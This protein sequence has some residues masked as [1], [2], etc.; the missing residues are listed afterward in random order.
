[1]T[2]ARPLRPAMPEV[3]APELAGAAD[4]RVFTCDLDAGGATGLAA[5]RALLSPDERRRAD[6]FRFERDR[7]RYTRGRAF[8]RRRL[9]TATQRPAATL[10]LIEG[11]WGKPAL[12]DGA[13]GFNLSHSGAIAVLA[14]RPDGG[15]VG[16]DVER[17]DRAVDVMRL[18]QSC[19]GCDERAVLA[20]LAPEAQRRRF[21]AFWTAKE[22]VMKLTG[23]GMSL[24]PKEIFLGLSD[25]H[26]VRAEALGW[27]ERMTFARM[28]FGDDGVECRL[29]IFGALSPKIHLERP[30]TCRGVR[31]AH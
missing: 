14:I 30:Q 17:I 31:K 26:P 12:Q 29:A 7:A 9:A 8:L 13:V 4:V 15:P 22:A 6:R 5:D 16:I 28:P 27:Q 1:M 11:E 21:F 3:T 19:F 20:A 24:A 10:R 2:L 25:G 23:Q 18:A